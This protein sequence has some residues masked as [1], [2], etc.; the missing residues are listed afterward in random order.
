MKI[1]TTRWFAVLA[2]VV[3]T[4]A[5]AS[6]AQAGL[7]IQYSLD[8]GAIGTLASGPEGGF[9]TYNTTLGGVLTLA[10]QALSNSPGTPTVSKLL[11]STVDIN[12]I[13]GGTHTLELFIGDT[14]FT[15]PAAPPNPAVLVNSHIGGSVVLINPL[16]TLSFTSCVDPTNT[17]NSC[18]PSI[19]AGVISAGPGTPNVTGIPTGS[20]SDDKFATITALGTPYSI[21]QY[22]VITLGS[23]GELNFANNTTLNP[24]PEPVSIVLLGGVVLL[25][26]RMIRRKAKQA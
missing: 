17:G 5:G 6:Q 11:A 8:G 2:L 3:L 1:F 22:L 4:V 23:G 20:F 10:G 21:S 13:S 19:P 26:N 25:T 12:N 9:V 7:L 16:N 24:V 18:G 14:G 15:A